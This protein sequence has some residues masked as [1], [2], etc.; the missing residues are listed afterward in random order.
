MAETANTANTANTSKTEVEIVRGYWPGAKC[1]AKRGDVEVT[2]EV[3]D[4]LKEGDIV[5][6]PAKEAAGLVRNG[7]ATLPVSE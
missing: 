6:L 4:G 7:I 1:T 5:S 3:G 2:I